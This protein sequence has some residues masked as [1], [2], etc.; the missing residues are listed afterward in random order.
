[1]SLIDDFSRK[2]WVY[3]LKSKNQSFTTFRVC[4]S[5]VENQSSIRIDNGF[6]FHFE[7][8]NQFCKAK[9]ISRHM[10]VLGTTQQNGVA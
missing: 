5:E 4:I 10:T 2:V 1:M 7:E 3:V 6:E 8:F 9:G